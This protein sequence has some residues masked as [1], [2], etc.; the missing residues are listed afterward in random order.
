MPPCASPQ[1]NR[2]RVCRRVGIAVW[3]KYFSITHRNLRAVIFDVFAVTAPILL[4][5]LRHWSG[6]RDG[7]WSDSNR[8]DGGPTCLRRRGP[9]RRIDGWGLLGIH[10]R[11]RRGRGRTRGCG[12][13]GGG[14]RC[15]GL[16]VAGGGLR[17]VLRRVAAEVSLFAVLG[18]AHEPLRG[19]LVEVDALDGRRLLRRVALLNDPAARGRRAEARSVY[20]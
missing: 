15:G 5:R 1:S 6:R 10:G 3:Y 7:R 17:S 14:R 9:N 20:R 11:R 18:H 2:S 19:G 12:S 13:T 16:M 8:R 4:G